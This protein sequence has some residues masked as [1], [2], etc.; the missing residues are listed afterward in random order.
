MNGGM[1]VT[2]RYDIGIVN[3]GEVCNFPLPYD[4]DYNDDVPV[5][6]LLLFA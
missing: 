3:G 2:I 5:K 6:A 1:E 4:T